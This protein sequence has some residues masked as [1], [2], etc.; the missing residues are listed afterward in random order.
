MQ[1]IL[2]D[3][4]GMCL[5]VDRGM[6]AVGITTIKVQGIRNDDKPPMKKATMQ[7]MKA[8]TKKKH[9]DE[10]EEEGGGKKRRRH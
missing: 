7:L 10:E 8:W 2:L 3:H 9:H 1:S 6:C 4:S 5:W